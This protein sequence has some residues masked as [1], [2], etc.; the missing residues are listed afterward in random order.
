ML[1]ERAFRAKQ[2]YVRGLISPR[3]YL[4]GKI[5]KCDWRQRIIGVPL[6]NVESAE[7]LN[8][9]FEIAMPSY[10]YVG[11]FFIGCD[12]GCGHGVSTHGCGLTCEYGD[13]KEFPPAVERQRACAH[14][15]AL[16]RVARADVVFAF[17]DAADAYGTILEIGA[18]VAL[19][20]PIGLVISESVAAS[21]QEDLWFV[22]H[23]ATRVFKG[24]P[25]AGFGHFLTMVARG[26][27]Q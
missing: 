20:K 15:L 6:R 19:G 10:K 5:S 21:V 8:P 13:S 1:H 12:H 3:V 22:E 4:A 16:H 23:S 7:A 25:R 9:N 2:N 24:C 14:R 11:P 27:L 17:I 18:A 26:N